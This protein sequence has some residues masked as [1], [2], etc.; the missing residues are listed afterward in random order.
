MLAVLPRRHGATWRTPAAP[1]TIASRYLLATTRPEHTLRPPEDTPGPYS[2]F[3][4]AL[5]RLQVLQVL[6]FLQVLQVLQVLQ[7]GCSPDPPD[8]AW[9]HLLSATPS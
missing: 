5:V 7:R 1:V 3:R 2:A 6:Q 9:G 4:R 8:R